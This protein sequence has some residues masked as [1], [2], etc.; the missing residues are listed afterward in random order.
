MTSQRSQESPD[1]KKT[2]CRVNILSGWIDLAYRCVHLHAV[3][4][5]IPLI[6]VLI[7]LSL[8][9]IIVIQVS[10][11]QSMLTK[12]KEQVIERQ[13]VEI[14][15]VV[16][17]LVNDKSRSILA[18]PPNFSPEWGLDPFKPMLR[19]GVAQRYT[20]PDIQRKLRNAFIKAGQ[21]DARFEFAIALASGS[22]GYEMASP[23]FYERLEISLQDTLHNR[24]SVWDLASAAGSDTENLTPNERL[25]IVIS[26]VKEY[27]IRSMGSMIAGMLVFT[28]LIIAAFYVTVR[29]LLRQKKLSEIKSDFIN[30]MTHE[31]KT[32][33]STIALAVDMLRKES[34]A[35]NEEQ[36]IYYADMIKS[37][38]NRMNQQV[39]TILD[40]AQL[41]REQIKL[42]HKSVHL[43]Q[44]L[45]KVKDHFTL[46]LEEKNGTLE[47]QL[48]SVNDMVS[49][50]EDYLT[51]MFDNLID[52]AIKYSRESVPPA[53]VVTSRDYKKFIRI[54][55]EDN[56]IGMNKETISKIFER[57]YRAHT[58]NVHNVK[59]FGIGLSYVR[60]IADAHQARIRVESTPGK[61][62]IFTIDFPKTT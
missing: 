9:G 50:D 58:G 6:T 51:T 22:G 61:G 23:G 54:R 25:I 26:D 35:T 57:F 13:H 43:H 46:K 11:F 33:L 12:R 34:V 16:E 2:K 28:F 24:L 31:L 55:V 1:S 37:E 48:E 41:D 32:P 7:T 19:P 36:R 21:P 60:S 59:G 52:N 5:A 62:S 3:K 15:K 53:I 18:P 4:K 47:L 29:T 38:N 42:K 56:G 44:I 10:L 17:D 27:A 30:N 14:Y 40:E 45:E 8:V 20:M 39:Q 49:A